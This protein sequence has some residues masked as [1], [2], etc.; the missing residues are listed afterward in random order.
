LG[1][2]PHWIDFGTIRPGESAEE[3][4]ELVRHGDAES[5]ED[6]RIEEVESYPAGIVYAEWTEDSDEAR[7]I[8]G[9]RLRI[10]LVA[11]QEYGEHQGSVLLKLSQ[12][13][14]PS[15]RISL[16]WR[17][18][19]VIAASPSHLFLGF[20]NPGEVRHGVVVVSSNASRKLEIDAAELVGSGE[21]SHVIWNR[22]SENAARFEVAVKLGKRAGLQ[23][24]D[25]RIHCAEPEERTLVVPITAFV[26]DHKANRRE[27]DE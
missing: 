15:L 18:E 5:W 4:V 22:D 13:W 1:V 8:S 19:D 7:E 10:R 27:S 12:C 17:V 14:E 11:P 24:T 3:I 16:I 20:G 21:D 23:K 2:R 26:A 25:L 6:C 9:R